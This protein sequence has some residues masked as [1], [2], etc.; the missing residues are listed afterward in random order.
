MKLCPLRAELFVADR[1]TDMMK[2]T[3]T[4]WSFVNVVKGGLRTVIY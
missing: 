2:P 1:W 4:F 3:V